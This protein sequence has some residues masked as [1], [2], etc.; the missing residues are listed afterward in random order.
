LREP[1]AASLEAAREVATA[2]ASA[3]QAPAPG[4]IAA[5]LVALA[6][7]CALHQLA[8]PEHADPD[9]VRRAARTLFIGHLVEQGRVD[10]AIRLAGA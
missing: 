2:A 3:A 4:E 9:A 10:E 7:G 5:T 1:V 6:H 8:L